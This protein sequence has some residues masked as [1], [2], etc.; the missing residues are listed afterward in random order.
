MGPSHRHCGY[1]EASFETPPLSFVH[2][3][4]RANSNGSKFLSCHAYTG[5]I[6]AN[7]YSHLAITHFHIYASFTNSHAA[8]L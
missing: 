7:I 1:H 5:R 4:V 6:P 8:G 2:G 3:L